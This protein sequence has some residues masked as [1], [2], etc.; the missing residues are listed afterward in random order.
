MKLASKNYRENGSR[1][2]AHFMGSNEYQTYK[3]G[4]NGK[5]HPNLPP[6]ERDENGHVVIWQGERFCRIE[7]C[8][9]DVSQ[10][11]PVMKVRFDSLKCSI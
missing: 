2:D 7:G 3:N 6:F 8:I 4:L 5:R 11:L 1:R 10:I 9:K